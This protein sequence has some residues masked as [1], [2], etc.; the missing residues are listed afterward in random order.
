MPSERPGAPG[1]GWMRNLCRRL[2]ASLPSLPEIL[3]G[4]PLWGLVMALSSLLALILRNGAETAHLHSILLL[5]FCGGLI[6][7][8]CALLLGRFCAL[9]RR[10]ETRF[11]AFFL[12]LTVF[13]IAATAFLFALDY[14]LF[15]ARWH[16]PF[17]SR[18]WAYQF[19]FTL[20]GAVYQFLVMGLRLYLP[21]GFAALGLTSL[22]L[23]NRMNDQRR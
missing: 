7:W 21:L 12:C 14:R 8:P 16:A 15:Y 3:L 2:A 4:S 20:A 19:V 10:R 11:A 1:R 18:I 5:F 6:A 9:G 13:T 17:G 22:W 23:A